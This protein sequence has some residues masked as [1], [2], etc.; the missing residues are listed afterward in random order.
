MPSGGELP[1]PAMRV[2][3]CSTGGAGHIQPM[4][5]LALALQRQGH[6]VGWA[7]AP[8]ALALVDGKGFALFAAGTDFATSR[9]RFAERYPEVLGLA[10]EHRSLQTFPRLFGATVAPAMLAELGSAIDRW[11]PDLVVHEPAAL[12]APL[13][14]ALRRVRH[15]THSF[16]LPVPPANIAAAM[17]W[18]GPVWTAFGLPVPT[19][20]ALYRHLALDIAPASMLLHPPPPCER[21]LTLNPYA[22]QQSARSALPED[23]RHALQTTGR[24]R[25]YLTFG[26][27]FHGERAL[28]RAAHALVALGAEV[29]VTVGA[30]G[31]LERFGTGVPHLHVRRYVEQAAVLPH[32]DAVV[33]H[34]GAGGVLGAAA[35]GLPH[36]VL[37]QGADHFRNGRALAES[38]AGIVLEPS[39]QT[40]EGIRTSAARL[41]ANGAHASASRRLALEMAAMPTADDAARAMAQIDWRN[42]GGA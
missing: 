25:V 42:A 13:A 30:D 22:V 36:L 35:H 21:R 3:F 17:R 40:L 32:C 16:G 34:G 33:S 19:D 37:P 14:C 31:D 5:P 38:G 1:A 9:R 7:T 8:D 12:A 27:V 28:V 20:G 4:R 15:A 24:P 26:T 41:L 39:S 11:Q 29:L 6:T 10:G 2:L 23:L 18:F